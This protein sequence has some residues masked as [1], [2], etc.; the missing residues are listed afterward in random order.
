VPAGEAIMEWDEYAAGWDDQP[1]VR[2]Y[3]QAAHRSLLLAAE[4]AGFEIAGSRACDFGCGTGLLT[5]Q[6]VASCDR[7][8]AVDS[9]PSMLDVLR[10][11]IAHHG[12]DEVQVFERLP[13]RRDH[14]DLVVC[15]SV[16]AFV[17]DYPGLVREL[18]SAMAP[19]G[20]FV[21][22]DWELDPRDDD[23]FGLTRVEIRRAFDA[24]GLVSVTVDTGFEVA[25]DDQTMRPLMGVGRRPT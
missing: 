7:I 2:L 15:S 13:P 24:A 9:S 4:A 6:L 16:C 20:L 22:W 25:V 21:Q 12:W 17:D 11:K 14:Y 19:D 10:R 8:D 3:A 5:E 23:P 18:V 1:G